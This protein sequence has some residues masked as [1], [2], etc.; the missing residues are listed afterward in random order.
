MKSTGTA[1]ITAIL[2]LLPA[3]ALADAIELTRPMQAASLHEGAID[4]VVY[5]LDHPDRDDFEVVATYASK[6]EPGKP[7]RIWID[8]TDGDSMSF[9][10]PYEVNR[11][12]IT[13]ER[14][15]EAA[16]KATGIDSEAGSRVIFS[17]TREGNTVQVSAKL[18]EREIALYVD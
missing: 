17:F 5:Y 2:T 10:L 1:L 16:R 7:S 9:D 6:A 4:M 15:W 12:A 8:L 13:D 11:S 3:A 14:V 18:T